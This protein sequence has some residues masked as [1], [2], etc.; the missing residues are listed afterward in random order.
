VAF[1]LLNNTLQHPG[2]IFYLKR[3]S[4]T[5]KLR[6]V[7]RQVRQE[8]QTETQTET[9]RLRDSSITFLLGVLIILVFYIPAWQHGVGPFTGDSYNDCNLTHIS[10]D[11]SAK[12]R[13]GAEQCPVTE[14]GNRDENNGTGNRFLEYH[15][16]GKWFANDHFTF[17]DSFSLSVKWMCFLLDRL[18]L[19][20]SPGNTSKIL[21]EIVQ[22]RPV[23]EDYKPLV[24]LMTAIHKYEIAPWW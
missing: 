12:L 14:T 5:E 22:T 18:I 15:E 4:S 6:K 10:F 9:E 23:L 19:T 13:G 17:K 16:T 3:S 7:F 8:T 24:L 2:K 1:G 21:M 20:T 11:I